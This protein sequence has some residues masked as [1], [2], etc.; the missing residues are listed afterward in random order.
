MCGRYSLFTPLNQVEKALQAKAVPIVQWQPAYNATPGAWLPVI[1]NEFTEVLQFFRWGLVPQWARDDK[2]GYGMNNTRSES[3]AEK[4]AFKNIFR[5][6]R[7]VV[8]AD[9]W[10]EW[11]TINAPAIPGSKKKPAKIKQPYRFHLP[12]NGLLLM[13]GLWDVWGEGLNSFSVITVPA[14]ADAAPVHDRMP[15]LLTSVQAGAWL[16]KGAGGDELLDLLKP[17]PAG[18]IKSYPVSTRLNTA[19]ENDAELI[20]VAELPK[21]PP[22]LFG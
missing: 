16:R 1:T 12:G 3:I 9:G 10:Y 14:N 18:T 4:P 22:T 7:C 17:V 5:Y 2:M 19:T 13:A 6:K 20:E 21:P 15:V 8:P 11:T